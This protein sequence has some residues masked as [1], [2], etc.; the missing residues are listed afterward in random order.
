M[1]TPD[2][3]EGP[4]ATPPRL[5]PQSLHS[6]P[7]PGL[8]WGNQ[9]LL[10]CMKHPDRDASLRSPDRASPS[11]STADEASSRP[12]RSP[13]SFS[14]P[15]TPSLPEK[16]RSPPPPAEAKRKL[17]LTRPN[18]SEEEEDESQP[19][20]RP[21]NLRTRR[22]ACRAPAEG[23]GSPAPEIQQQRLLRPRL[24]TVGSDGG[25]EKKKERPRFSVALS[26]EEIEEDLFGLT[27]CRPSRRPKKRPK[28]TQRFLDMSFP[29]LWLTEVTLD[30]YKVPD[31]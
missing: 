25:G 13:L 21:W 10:R 15:S 11:R 20:V 14:T 22:A 1:A 30:I 18:A 19:S 7:L 23:I 17:L 26:R 31:S 28:S 29:G 5:K 16:H 6:F 24:G 2:L 4:P 12:H 8:R 27:G 3:Y 9:R